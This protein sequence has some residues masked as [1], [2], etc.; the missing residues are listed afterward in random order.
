M[1]RLGWLVLLA[2]CGGGGGAEALADCAGDYLGTFSGDDEGEASATLGADG[3]LTVTFLSTAGELG[4]TGTVTEDGEVS[5]SDQGT[6]VSGTL[7]FSGCTMSG[8]WNTL[9]LYT[10]T[11]ELSKQ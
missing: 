1:P 9:G 11:W 3:T 4:S 10:G 8:T 5:G 6:T 7:D 2:G